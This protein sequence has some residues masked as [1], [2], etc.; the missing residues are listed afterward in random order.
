M[1]FP[2]DAFHVVLEQHNV[3]KALK[4]DRRHEEITDDRVEPLSTEQILNNRRH[5]FRPVAVDGDRQ[6]GPNPLD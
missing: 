2:D 5:P 6:R 3:A 4:I 1:A